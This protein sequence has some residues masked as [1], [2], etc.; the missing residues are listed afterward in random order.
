MLTGTTSF[1]PY[2]I[3]RSDAKKQDTRQHLLKR[4]C[5]GNIDMATLVANFPAFEST[6]NFGFG[7]QIENG[8][9]RFM[10]PPRCTAGS[11]QGCIEMAGEKFAAR[12]P[13]AQAHV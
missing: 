3:E 1:R 13:P 10:T 4:A 2:W 12:S 5:P 11:G 9:S 8:C 7:G 6:G